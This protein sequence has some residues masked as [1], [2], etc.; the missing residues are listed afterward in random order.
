MKCSLC[1]ADNIDNGKF[2]TSCGAALTKPEDIKPEISLDQAASDIL[3]GGSESEDA[4]EGSLNDSVNDVEEAVTQAA[5]DMED[6]VDN[7]FEEMKGDTQASEESDDTGSYSSSDIYDEN[8]GGKPGFA[9]ASLVCGCLSIICCCLTCCAFP[10]P[11][12]A[13]VL[14]VIAIVKDLDGRGLAIA[15]I[16]T[17]G[18][19]L[20]LQLI[21][22]IA[23]ASEG[24]L[25]EIF[26]TIGI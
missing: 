5:S 2:C 7:A 11:V 10:L 24:E 15:G 20:I 3:N 9:I 22:T 4:I 25:S 14:G 6:A 1:G 26:G 16:A 17:G 19:G 21:F 18:V 13:I 23:A 8:Q 12:A